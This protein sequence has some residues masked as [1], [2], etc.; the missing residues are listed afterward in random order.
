MLPPLFRL[1]RYFAD[2]LIR[3]FHAIF[4]FRVERFRYAYYTMLPLRR[5]R[6]FRRC[7]HCRSRL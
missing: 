2:C 6:D 4:I 7:R 3:H 1:R 5:R